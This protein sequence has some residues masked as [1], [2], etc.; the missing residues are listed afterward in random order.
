MIITIVGMVKDAADIIESYIR[1]NSVYADN[2]VLFDHFSSDRTREIINC[3]VDE[4]FN[5]EM[6]TM[7]AESSLNQEDVTTRLI[8]Y[9]KEKYDSDYIIALDDDEVICLSDTASACEEIQ[10]NSDG[11]EISMGAL[12][13]KQISSLVPEH[14]F[15][16][17]WRNYF[18]SGNTNEICPMR[19]MELYV[20][21]PNNMSK[22][23]VPGA[24]VDDSFRIHMGNH[25]ASSDKIVY[26]YNVGTLK[27][28]HFPIRSEEQIKKKVMVGYT[29]L[30]TIKNRNE[31]WGFHWRNIYERFKRNETISYEELNDIS[32]QSYTTLSVDELN[33]TKMPLGFP[34]KAY[35]IMY[36]GQNEV[37]FL[38]SYVENVE[39]I[40]K[41]YNSLKD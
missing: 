12:I 14:L 20:D 23:I 3:L 28:A 21:D 6:Y 10:T 31:L 4:G 30:M 8:K 19:R 26:R 27:V 35:E 22:V 11:G 16:V 41:D 1:F 25:D 15:Y 29:N 32:R 34:Q 33:L 38:R 5:I 39:R 13:R 37:N 36:T 18:I 9:A 7:E 17:K 40:I 2:F 24:I